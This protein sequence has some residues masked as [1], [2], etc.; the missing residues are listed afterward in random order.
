MKYI[1]GILFLC[2]VSACLRKE[3]TKEQVVKQG[4][5]SQTDTLQKVFISELLGDTGQFVNLVE[6]DPSIIQDIRYA[7]TANFTKQI[8][9]PCAACF[10]QNEVAQA[11]KSAQ[12]K[13][14][15]MGFN[16]KVF[17]CYRSYESQVKLYE[18]FPNFNYVAK[19]SKGSMHSLGCA[20]D[21]T[22]VDSLGN[23]LNMGTSFDS[24]NKESYTYSSTIDSTAQ[25]NRTLLRT[26][27]QGVGFQ[28]I[29]TEWWHFSF[30]NCNKNVP[31]SLQWTCE[32]HN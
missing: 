12:E 10:L 16:I 21:L 27:M 26:L 30:K 17:D 18:A 2:V 1:V 32:T 11:L 4:E 19:P 9:Y 7:D 3:N 29:K 23:E 15:S 22:L 28:E 5:V 25:Y 20:V 6:L 14:K 8:I 31:D 13:A 24:F